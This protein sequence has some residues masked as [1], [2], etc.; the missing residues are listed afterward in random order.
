MLTETVYGVF[1]SGRSDYNCN[2]WTMRPELIGS[3]YVL[4]IN[5]IASG[6]R[7]RTFCYLAVGLFYSN[8]YV[9]LFPVGA[10]LH[11]FDSEFAGLVKA[12]W[13]K[14]VLFLV[15]LF[16]CVGLLKWPNVF[17]GPT[18]D[19]MY[20][21]MLAAALLVW[22]VLHW[23]LLQLLLGNALGRLLG[24]ISFVLY[25]VHVPIICSLTAWMVLRLPSGIAIPAAA[26]TTV[27]AVFLVSIATH[28]W[29]DQIPT[30]WSRSVGY[31]IDSLLAGRSA[32]QAAE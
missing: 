26:A 22:S 10:L 15:G 29:I 24:H 20:W 30:R 18:P 32:R 1:V 27:V 4:L 5:A 3:L 25:L 23:R 17:P 9:V 2:L 28:R 6:R 19:G 7:L 14:A 13:L 21:H 12:A 31:I 8:D 11:D 16:L